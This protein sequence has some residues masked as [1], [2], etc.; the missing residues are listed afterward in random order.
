[1]AL[2]RGLV[3]RF[4]ADA[5][6][7]AVPMDAAVPRAGHCDRLAWGWYSQNQKVK[8]PNHRSELLPKEK[9]IDKYTLFSLY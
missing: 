1:M 6:A 4:L 8:N 3:V 5:P 2:S 9:F 7:R